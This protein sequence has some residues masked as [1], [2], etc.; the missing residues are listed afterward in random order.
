[1]NRIKSHRIPL[2]L[3]GPLLLGDG[4]SPWS[5]GRVKDLSSQV[6]ALPAPLTAAGSQGHLGEPQICRR[7]LRRVEFV[8]GK[9]KAIPFAILLFT[10]SHCW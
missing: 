9:A 1:M 5:L 3:Q 10:I 4:R 8:L 2:C 6:A 7:L